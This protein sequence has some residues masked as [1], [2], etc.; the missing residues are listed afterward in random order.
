[1]TMTLLMTITPADDVAADDAAADDAAVIVHDAAGAGARW[2]I[3]H[4][5]PALQRPPI[6]RPSRSGAR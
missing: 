4:P 6:L 5:A 3:N 2:A 1:M